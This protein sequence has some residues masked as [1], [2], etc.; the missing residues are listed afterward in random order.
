MDTSKGS[1]G[2]YLAIELALLEIGPTPNAQCGGRAPTHDAADVTYS[3]IAAG[4]AG[5]DA[6]N[7]LAPKIADGV[8]VHP[9]VD[10]SSFPFLGEPR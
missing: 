7:G 10:D 6:Q 1:C 9:D 8:Q 4:A 2:S 5:F 3:L